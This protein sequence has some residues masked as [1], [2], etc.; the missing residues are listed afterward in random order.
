MDRV[1]ITGVGLITSIGEGRQ[2][3]WENLLAGRSGISEVQSFDTS[4]YS[5]HRGGEIK[6]FAPEKYV[7]N[8][9]PGELGRSSQLAIAASY[10]ALADA[11]MDPERLDPVMT[12]VSMGTTS[13]EP[14]QVERFNDALV[15]QE[16]ERIGPEFIGRYPCHRIAGYVAGEFGL[17]GCNMMI[18]AACAAGN[19][20]MAYAFDAIRAG[21]ADVMLAGGADAFSRI[22]YTGFA[23]LFAIAP[24]KCQPFALNRKGMMPGEGAGILVLES[25]A[26]AQ[27]RNAPI[28]AEVAGYGLSCDAFHMTGGHPQGDG[29]A[30]AMRQALTSSGLTP[31]EVDYISAHGTGTKS[32]DQHETVAVKKVF[33][34]A[35]YRTPISS[36]K[37]MIGHTMGAAS[38][39]ESVVCALAISTSRIP[40]TINLDEPDPECDLDYVPNVAREHTVRVAMNNAYAFGG[41]NASLILR[42]FEG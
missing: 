12:G 11:G 26:N 8:Q 35:A 15:A 14:N 21:R 18:P 2:T 29:A 19:Y 34:D 36:I 9:S 42:K 13:G 7:R 27:N 24:E 20:A 16:P 31:E 39:I 41:T 40:P 25:L 37:S 1:V 6:R 5:V 17:T 30:R 32:N 23:R 4:A 33:A 3:F 10:L 22:T 38:A 28:Y